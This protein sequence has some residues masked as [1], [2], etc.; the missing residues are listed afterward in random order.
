MRDSIEE[1]GLDE[2]V[3]RHVV[4]DESVANPEVAVEGVIADGVASE[5]TETTQAVALPTGDLRRVVALAGQGD[6]G[7]GG[8]S[9]ACGLAFVHQEEVGSIRHFQNI[10]HVAGRRNV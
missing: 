5:T 6:C 10:W 1:S 8:R 7:G 2:S 3:V 4:E 9:R